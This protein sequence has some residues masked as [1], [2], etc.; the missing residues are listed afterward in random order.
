M[1]FKCLLL[2]RAQSKHLFIIIIIII[3]IISISNKVFMLS[4]VHI[5][6]NTLSNP[7]RLPGCFKKIRGSRGIYFKCVLMEGF[8][9]RHHIHDN[10]FSSHLVG[11]SLSSDRRSEQHG[12]EV[13]AHFFL[14]SAIQRGIVASDGMPHNMAAWQCHR[15]CDAMT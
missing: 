12:D 2:Y 11:P 7:K 14:G 6:Y 13:R 10:H 5:I 4:C 9:W 8:D 15:R 3:I 1:S